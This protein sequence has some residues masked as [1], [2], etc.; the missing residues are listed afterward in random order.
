MCGEDIDTHVILWALHKCGK[1]KG[2]KMDYSA[3]EVLVICTVNYTT[4][5]AFSIGQYDWTYCGLGNRIM[6]K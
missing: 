2:L 3:L 6:G 5:L 1:V 4:F